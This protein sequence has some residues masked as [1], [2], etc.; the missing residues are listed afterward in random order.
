MEEFLTYKGKPLVRNGKRIYYGNAYDKYILVMTILA[1]KTENGVELPSRIVVQIQD[2]NPE[3]MFK[4]EQIVKQ[5]EKQ[6][7]ADALEIGVTWLE[8]M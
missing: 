3:L 8:C 2:T 7:L 4:P 5:T 1:T 6:T